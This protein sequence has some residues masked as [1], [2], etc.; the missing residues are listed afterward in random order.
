MKP[1]LLLGLLALTACKNQTPILTFQKGVNLEGWL[2]YPPFEALSKEHLSELQEVQKQGFDFVRVPIDPG[3]FLDQDSISA[4]DSLK[5]LL[6]T[7]QQNNLKVILDF[8]PDEDT[9]KLPILKEE[10]SFQVYL[11]LLEKFSEWLKPFPEVALELMDEP[12]DPS[13]DDCE[14]S[15]FHWEDLQNQMLSA[16]R[17]GNQDLTVVLSGDCFS[18]MDALMNLTPLQDKRVVYTF[19]YFERPIFTQQGTDLYG[20]TEHLKNV[21]YPA[22]SMNPDQLLKTVPE[23]QQSRVKERLE[24]YQGF[25]SET[26]QREFAEVAAWSKDHQ[27]AVLLGAYGVHQ[28]APAQDRQQWLQDVQAAAEKHGFAHAVWAWNGDYRMPRP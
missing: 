11:A 1:L 8:F 6:D 17:K 15:A 3:F 14:P 28:N 19:H 13:R 20:F 18:G 10:N 21:P 25:G 23:E 22:S 4:F 2:Q 9:L 16:V 5:S 12:F 27:V 7:A 24:K 26:I